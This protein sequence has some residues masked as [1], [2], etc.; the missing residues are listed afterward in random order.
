MSDADGLHYTTRTLN[1]GSG[2]ILALGFGLLISD[3]IAT[4]EAVR[5]S[6]EVGFRRFDCA[7]RNLLIDH[8]WTFNP[9]T[10]YW[11]PPTP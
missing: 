3:P 4:T 1:N 2:E 6:L 11:M 5:I 9:R 8:G 7:E 10:N